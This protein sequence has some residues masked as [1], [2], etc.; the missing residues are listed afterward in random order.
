MINLSCKLN[1]KLST[2][3]KLEMFIVNYLLD[4]P[5]Q[6]QVQPELLHLYMVSYKPRKRVS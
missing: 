3:E 6:V 5:D 2:I 1:F 4:N